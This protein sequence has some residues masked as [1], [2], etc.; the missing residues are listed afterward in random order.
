MAGGNNYPLRGN[1]ATIW[2]GGTRSA[3][4]I[5]G[6]KILGNNSLYLK[7]IFSQTVYLSLNR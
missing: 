4:F 2:E 6:P 3:A 1:K 5:H 7:V